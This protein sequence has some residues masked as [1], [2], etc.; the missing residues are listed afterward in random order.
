MHS[1]K[2]SIFPPPQGGGIQKKK[3]PKDHLAT[4]LPSDAQA[5]IRGLQDESLTSIQHT[6]NPLEASRSGPWIAIVA[7]S[8]T[9]ACITLNAP[10]THM[11]LC[12]SKQIQFSMPLSRSF[13]PIEAVTCF[14]TWQTPA[15]CRDSQPSGAGLGESSCV[16]RPP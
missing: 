14:L 15:H 1:R 7:L 12:V 10:T 4:Q 5:Q 13:P 2:Y 16:F 3:P 9:T 11:D 8:T 6:H